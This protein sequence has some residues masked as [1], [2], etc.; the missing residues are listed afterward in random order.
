MIA[1]LRRSLES[2]PLARRLAGDSVWVALETVASRGGLIVALW[3]AARALGPAEFGGLVAVQGTLVLVA[4]IVAYAVRVSAACEMGGTAA[5]ARPRI[6]ATVTW[7]AVGGGVLLALLLAASAAPVAARLLARPDLT[8]MLRVG[9]VLVLLECGTAL[10]LGLLAGARSMRT[11]AWT[12]A[13]ASLVLIAAVAG[14]V[15]W[16]GAAGAMWGL[17]AGA[18]TSVVLRWLPVRRE[19]ARHR[20]ALFEVP[21]RDQLATFA[22]VSLPTV[23]LNLLWTPTV[24]LGTLLLLRADDGYVEL[25]RLGAAN[26]WFAALLFL[27]NVLGFASLPHL[28]AADREGTDSL[29]ATAGL[30]VRASV[31]AS[32]ALAAI[33][34]LASPWIMGLYGPDYREA[35]PALAWLAAATVPAAAFGIVGNVLTVT[36]RW[37][38]LLGAQA[39]WAACYLGCA[40][41]GIAAGLGATALGIAMLVGNVARLLWTR[42]HA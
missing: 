25:G 17:V 3:L 19:L 5:G 32:A 30:A 27:P 40:A 15:A 36:G 4:S 28:S 24:W 22:R 35:W 11:A 37:R 42:R 20:V 18:T 16:L 29:R 26:Q 12:A 10:Q 33:A 21:Q 9:S 41:V 14:G 2:T 1:A 13:V 8:S 7:V 6:L 31:Y 38:P 23:A 34:M 39:A